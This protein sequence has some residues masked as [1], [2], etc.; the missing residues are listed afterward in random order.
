MRQHVL[1]RA[2]VAATL[3]LA[4]CATIGDVPGPALRAQHALGVRRLLVL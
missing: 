3:A 2:L 4:A 1:A